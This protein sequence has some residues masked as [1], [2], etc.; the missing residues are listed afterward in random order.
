MIFLFCMNKITNAER[1]I[2]I[3]ARLMYAHITVSFGTL[4]LRII[5]LHP[6]NIFS[7]IYWCVGG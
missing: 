6:K 4:S 5:K 2:Q 1:R 7:S 3:I